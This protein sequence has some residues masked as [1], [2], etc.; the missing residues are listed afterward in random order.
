MPVIEPIF[1]QRAV[2]AAGT[3]ERIKE[4][5]E[6]SDS[7]VIAIHITANLDNAGAV[8]LTD[9]TNRGS[10]STVSKILNPGDNVDI[11]VSSIFDAWIDLSELWIDAANSGDAINYI[12]IRVIR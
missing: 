8:Y 1:A 3:P 4:G 5:P 6:Q 10:A 9:N 7:K 12:A 2:T 11:D